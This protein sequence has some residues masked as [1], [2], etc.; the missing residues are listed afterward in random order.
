MLK[1]FARKLELFAR[2]VEQQDGAACGALCTADALY[3]DAIF[4]RD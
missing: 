1:N 4:W 3:K 2:T